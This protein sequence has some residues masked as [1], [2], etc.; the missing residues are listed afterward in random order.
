M[1]LTLEQLAMQDDVRA[2]RQQQRRE[3]T[4]RRKNK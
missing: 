4:K 2:S 3:R 1:T